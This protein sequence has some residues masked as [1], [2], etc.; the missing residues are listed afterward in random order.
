MR[1][2]LPDLIVLQRMVRGFDFPHL[3]EPMMKMSLFTARYLPLPQPMSRPMEPVGRD[4]RKRSMMGHG[5]ESFSG[6]LQGT[7]E[8][9]ILLTLYLVD[10]K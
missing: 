4:C 6:L 1:V 3:S 5:C 2:N 8:L 9:V 7:C 10:E